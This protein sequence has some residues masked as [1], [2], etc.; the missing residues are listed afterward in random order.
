[1][2]FRSEGSGLSLNGLTTLSRA[3]ARDL[4]RLKGR[5][6][7]NGLTNVDEVAGELAWGH[8]HELSLD[9]VTE[10]SDR[11]ATQ[12]GCLRHYGGELSLSGL[13]TLADPA[14]RDLAKGRCSLRLNGLTTLS[15]GAAQKLAGCQ[16][17]LYLNG[18]TTLSEAAAEALSMF[19]GEALHVDNLQ[20]P[21][22]EAVKIRSTWSSSQSPAEIL[23][24]GTTVE[25]P[26]V[27][28]YTSS[29]QTMPVRISLT[30]ER[31]MS[32]LR[33]LAALEKEALAHLE[34][35]GAGEMRHYFIE[36]VRYYGDSVVFDY[37]T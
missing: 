31:P 26:D 25:L 2:L 37:G 21:L 22:P 6:E 8:L 32:V 12:L 10:L 17:E 27:W 29:G 13:K 3:A 20:Q 5:L 28:G 30:L 15:E 23:P 16:H 19:Q 11:A 4:S 36:G 7:L 34:Q 33:A 1:V 9:G 35:A 24:A 18:L 14:A